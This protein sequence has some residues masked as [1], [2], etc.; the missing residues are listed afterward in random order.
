MVVYSVV[1]SYLS[2]VI[3]S[4]LI[5]WISE[6]WVVCF[7]YAVALSQS[8]LAHKIKIFNT[9]WEPWHFRRS[10]FL[11]IF[12]YQLKLS[13]CLLYMFLLLL[14]LNIDEKVCLSPIT[15]I[16][17]LWFRL[18]SSHVYSVVCQ[19][20]NGL[21][22]DTWGFAQSKLQTKPI[23]RFPVIKLTL[24]VWVSSLTASTH[25]VEHSYVLSREQ[26]L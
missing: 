2:D 13:D 9:C 1:K 5:H 25:C 18:N 15:V 7:L 11:H 16:K 17:Y 14:A 23:L 26:K 12:S 3:S 20:A 24:E 8:F 6:T 10:Y 4:L 22:Q 19:D 21:V